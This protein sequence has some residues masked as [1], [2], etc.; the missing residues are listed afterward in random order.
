[1]K[2]AYRGPCLAKYE[3][4]WQKNPPAIPTPVQMIDV[5]MNARGVYG[6]VS[7]ESCLHG[8]Q[9]YVESNGNDDRYQSFSLRWQWAPTNMQDWPQSVLFLD[10]QRM[11]GG[12]RCKR[13]TIYSPPSSNQ[14][15][16]LTYSG[17]IS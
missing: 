5:D 2:E 4:W 6:S 3:E 11:G 10:V 1:M 12:F 14:G 17:S 7:V 9:Q 8:P 13:T 15:G 16:G